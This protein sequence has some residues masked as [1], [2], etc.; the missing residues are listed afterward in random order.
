MTKIGRSGVRLRVASAGAW[1]VLSAASAAQGANDAAILWQP[2]DSSVPSTIEAGRDAAVTVRVYNRG[3]TTWT[4]GGLYRLGARYWAPANQVL[5]IPGACGGYLNSLT[6]ARIFLC[7]DV[8]PGASHDFS[9]LISTP[10]SEPRSVRLGLRM[11]Q[12][13][14]EWFGDDHTWNIGVTA[15]PRNDA[16][17]LPASSSVPSLLQAGTAAPVTIRVYNTGGTTW[18]AG[19]LYRLGAL[20]EGAANQVHWSGWSCGGYANSPTDARAFLC[21]DVPPGGHHDFGFSITAPPDA[22]STVQLAVWMVQDG[23]EWFGGRHTWRIPLAA[24]GGGN[25]AEILRQGPASDVPVQIVAEGSAPV[26]VRVHNTGSTTW[27]A[28]SLYRLGALDDNQ[29]A[30]AVFGCGGYANSPQDSRVELCHDVPPGASHDFT[31]LI[32]PPPAAPGTAVRFGVRMVQD[33]VEWFGDGQTFRIVITTPVNRTWGLLKVRAYVDGRSQL[34][35]RGRQAHWVHHDFAA[36]GRW[37]LADLPT[38]LNDRPWT[39]TWPA[40]FGPEVR[41]CHCPSS[42]TEGI[43]ALPEKAQIVRLRPLEV[44]DRAEIVQQPSAANDYTLV[45]ELDDNPSSGADWYEVELSYESQ[46]LDC[47]GAVADLSPSGQAIAAEVPQRRFCGN[48]FSRLIPTPN[49]AGSGREAYEQ[50]ADLALG[51]RHEVLFTTMAWDD[52][53]FTGDDADPDWT[54]DGPGLIFLRGVRDLYRKLQQEGLAEHPEGI[55]VRILLGFQH[56]QFFR[57]PWDPPADLRDQRLFVG[58]A[59]ARLGV[60]YDDPE[61]KWRVQVGTYRGSKDGLYTLTEPLKFSHA[62]FMVVDGVHLIAAGYNMDYVHLS[63]RD[64]SGGPF[65]AMLDMGIKVSGPVAQEAARTFAGLWSG[66]RVCRVRDS[67]CEEEPLTSARPHAARRTV[68]T[69]DT[70]SFSLFRNDLT[71]NSDDAINAAL[72]AASSRILLLQNR[73]WDNFG[74]VPPPSVHP[75]DPIAACLSP[76]ADPP[77]DVDDD[78]PMSYSDSLISALAR[79]VEVRMILSGGHTTD[80]VLNVPSVLRLKVEIVTRF[81]AQAADMLLRLG[82][83]YTR[84]NNPVHTKAVMIDERVMIVGSQN[85]DYSAFDDRE[86]IDLVEYNIAVDDARAASAF[87]AYF[88]ELWCRSIFLPSGL[89]PACPDR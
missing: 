53:Q 83:V 4:A 46:P 79:G 49:A 62:K 36:P 37:L 48:S 66:A 50:F 26:R 64:S 2:G 77:C 32:A 85:W 23:V 57:W 31:F 20:F 5:W 12:D 40:D 38:Y 21:H 30:W 28:G 3:T 84:D 86:P 55:T 44:R 14:V 78:G 73:Y 33:G 8:P 27:T 9:F 60:P 29:V 41:D 81:P 63:S 56:N 42:S 22:S 76:E 35:V 18:T 67:V 61:L 19:G 89:P 71:K 25:D 43:P 80:L 13:G 15:R 52:E 58:S 17:I 68:V 16:E 70:P 69:G 72:N 75:F 65:I 59:L 24:S 82:V 47:S 45:L 54:D 39:P 74:V 11:V 7:H 88:E 10:F 87:S 34:V 1:F 51:A 6:D